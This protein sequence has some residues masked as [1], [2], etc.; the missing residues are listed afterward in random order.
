MVKINAGELSGRELMSEVMWEVLSNKVE[1]TSDLGRI[2][3][4]QR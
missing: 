1:L 4:R 3:L 2:V